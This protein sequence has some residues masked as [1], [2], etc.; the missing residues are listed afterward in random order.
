VQ[1][2]LTALAYLSG[3]AGFN[4][5]QLAGF[6]TAGTATLLARALEPTGKVSLTIADLGGLDDDEETWTEAR[7]QAGMLRL[8]GLRTA[9]LL[10]A[11]GRLVLHHPGAHFDSAA[12]RTAYRTLGL[13]SSLEISESPWSVGAVLG[14]LGANDRPEQK[15]R[16]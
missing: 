10:A 3:P 11:P 14:R 16:E 8:G 5:V 7:A 2:V 1:D 9:A 6:G 15:G 12:I 13:A 4:E